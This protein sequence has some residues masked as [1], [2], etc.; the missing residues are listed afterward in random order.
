MN[1][2][3]LLLGLGDDLRLVSDPISNL[4]T[5][6]WSFYVGIRSCMKEWGGASC[7]GAE[8][9]I[10]NL[11]FPEES[12]SQWLS[13]LPPLMNSGIRF[14]CFQSFR[15]KCLSKSNVWK[16]MAKESPEE[17]QKNWLTSPLLNP[18]GFICLSPMHV[19][20]LIELFLYDR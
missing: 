4:W 10:Y 18:K 8:F 7:L 16:Q 17:H 1:F 12:Q 20:G 13:T 2:H 11:K 15:Y 5:C 3:Q 9:R 19:L 14:K 6:S